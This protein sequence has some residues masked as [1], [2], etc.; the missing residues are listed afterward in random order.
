MQSVRVIKLPEMKTVYSGPLTDGEAF[1]RFVAWFSSYHASLANELYPRDFMWYNERLGVREW[2]YALPAGA[3]AEDCG[4]FDIVD[5]PDGLF[6]VASCMN[7]DF[8]Q[9]A[10]WLA[11]RGELMKW[12]AEND[13]FKAYENGEGKRER[14]P[15]FHI[16][17][18]G[19]MYAENISVE[20]LYLPIERR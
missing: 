13:R 12:A 9:A 6:A 19:E 8:D 7:A 10:D 18:P 15:M 1:G 20:D 4:G 17:S 14:Y 16:V 11:T 5:L 3:R 2:F